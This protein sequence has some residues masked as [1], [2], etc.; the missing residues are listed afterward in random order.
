MRKLYISFIA[1]YSINE[2]IAVKAIE[3]RLGRV[4]FYK[5]LKV[6]IDNNGDDAAH[7]LAKNLLVHVK[8]YAQ[9]Q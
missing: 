6:F 9:Y 3:K 4:S 5:D 1:R 8:E 7:F 2:W